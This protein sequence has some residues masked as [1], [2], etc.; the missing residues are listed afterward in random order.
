M[1]P[2]KIAI[3]IPKY[4]TVGGAERFVA[5]LTERLASMTG[6]EFH[7]IANRWAGVGNSSVQ[8]HF[9]PR[10]A[11]PRS[12]RPWAFARQVERKIRGGGFDLVH[13]HDRIFSAD[14]VSLHCVPH[15]L[16]VEKVLGKRKSLFDRSTSAVERRMIKSADKTTFLPVSSLA[17]DTFRDEYRELP[18]R[19]EVV[20]PGVDCAR[21]TARSRGQCRAE[22]RARHGIPH[23]SYVVLFAGMNFELKGLDRIMQSVSV[24]RARCS[25]QD[26]RLLVAGGGHIEK[27]RAKAGS[28]GLSDAVTFAGTVTDGLEMYYLAADTFMM[29]SAFDTF[30]M[31]VLEAMASGLP[32]IISKNVGARDIVQCG[33]SGF[34]IDNTEDPSLLAEHILSLG[35]PGEAQLLGS[36]GAIIAAEHDWA[37]T[38]EKMAEVYKAHLEKRDG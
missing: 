26:I 20:H 38:A 5:E 23:D 36:A 1:R 27:Y 22:I 21:F 4:G 28:L 34:V 30:G 17:M 32:V 25:G 9:I 2:R 31:V 7:V 33:R 12:L 10:L 3:A 19:W 8:F 18:G 16:W 13:S 24:A 15:S 14:V 6:D 35:R 29:L 11:F 37:K